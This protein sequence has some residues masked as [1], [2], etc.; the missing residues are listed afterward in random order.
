MYLFTWYFSK[1][2]LRFNQTVPTSK[3]SWDDWDSSKS[4]ILI[5]EIMISYEF[6]KITDRIDDYAIK[7]EFFLWE[8]PSSNLRALGE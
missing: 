4:L 5:V 7:E 3:R 2:I 1:K 6:Y 8:T